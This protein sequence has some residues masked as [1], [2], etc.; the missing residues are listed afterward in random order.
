MVVIPTGDSGLQRA[1]MARN[2]LVTRMPF[3]RAGVNFATVGFTAGGFQSLPFKGTVLKVGLG[4]SILPTAQSGA[5]IGSMSIQGYRRGG[6]TVGSAMAFPVTDTVDSFL[7]TTDNGVSYT[8]YTGGAATLNSLDTLANGDWYLVGHSTPFSAVYHDMDDLNDTASVLA[9]HYVS[10][11]VDDV[12]TFTAMPNVSDG[13]DVAGDTLKQD[14]LVSWDDGVHSLWRQATFE[15]LTKYW[16]RFTVSVALDSSVSLT[17]A[18]PQRVPGLFYEYTPTGIERH[19]VE[20]DSYDFRVTV[21]DAA[22][23]DLLGFVD[24]GN[25]E[26]TQRRSPTLL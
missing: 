11:N 10:A 22:V 13:T 2:A 1:Q 20:S 26:A 24:Y 19:M 12:A 25:N 9:V 21:A 4:F 5:T 15:G 7:V 23:G 17:S 14:G 16:A 6:E 8:P 18:N 3:G